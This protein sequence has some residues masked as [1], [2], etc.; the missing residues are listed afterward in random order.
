VQLGR[1]VL[2]LALPEDDLRRLTLSPDGRRLATAGRDRLML[3]EA[4]PP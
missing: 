2:F 4:G 3:W 1:E